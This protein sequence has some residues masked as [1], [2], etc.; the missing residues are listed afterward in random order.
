VDSTRHDTSIVHVR[1]IDV[2]DEA[3][4]ADVARSGLPRTRLTAGMLERIAPLQTTDALTFVPGL[5]VRNY[6]GAGGLKTISLRGGS[7]A[8]TLVLLDGIR[9]NSAQNGQV[10]LAMIP[11]TM[12]GSIDVTRGG[13]TALYGANALTGVVDFRLKADDR[14]GL[15]AT[16]SNG[17]FDESRWAAAGSTSFGALRMAAGVDLLQTQGSFPF[18][19]NAFGRTVDINRENADLRSLGAVVRAE[20]DDN[21]TAFAVVR[22]SDRGVP[23]AVVQGSVALARARLNDEDVLFGI[24]DRMTLTDRHALEFSAGL[25]YFDQRYRDPDATIRGQNGLDERYLLRDASV[26]VQ[27]K[28][29]D[30]VFVQ[31]VR[32][33]AGVTDLRGASLQADVGSQVT[34]RTAA[35][36]ANWMVL[37]WPD[38][39][40]EAGVRL[41]GISDVSTAVS[42]LVG[43]RW[44]A[45][46]DVT[47][48]AGWSYN[49]RPPSFN[50]LYYLNFGTSTL[51]PERSHT[52][53]IGCSWR[54]VRWI[55]IEADAFALD[56]RDLI[57]AVPVSPILT[58]AQNVGRATTLGIE[59]SARASLFDERLM[60]HW[61]YTLQDARD[62]T[63]RP[64]IDGSLIPYIP[65]EIAS[66]GLHWR[67]G[68]VQGG[69]TLSSTSHRYAL[70]G[71]QYSTLLPRFTVMN[72][73][74]GVRGHT[75]HMHADVRL[76]ADNL[77]DEGYQVV[78]GFPMPGRTLR[79]IAS[80]AWKAR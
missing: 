16:Y 72:A 33:D 68:I 8:Q 62:R 45:S 1:T 7:S 80:L 74:V 64:G 73:Y 60:I 13:A 56:T 29:V 61:S 27:W 52:V 67:D 31:T 79:I 39:N 66:G 20:Y 47:L 57:V 59:W 50:E 71:E 24:R 40:V 32:V 43:L 63:G 53:D 37:P 19:M 46:S 6:G 48:K 49:F 69:M 26:G 77:L 41:E 78:R 25:R 11:M 15:S 55:S 12:I 21:L 51:R 28:Y 36:A 35:I 23:G 18:T 30:P 9:L 42:P 22:S 70:P 17:S 4:L 2:T 54:P 38:V 76:Q 3:Y 58:S 34:R 10:D 65:Q 75:D 44:D 5:S 14:Q